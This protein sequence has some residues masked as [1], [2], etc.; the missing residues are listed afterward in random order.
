MYMKKILHR[1]I[2]IENILIGKKADGSDADPG[3]RGILIDLYMAIQWDGDRRNLS[4]EQRLVC[5]FPRSQYP[6]A[7]LAFLD[8]A[9][10]SLSSALDVL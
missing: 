2:T 7:D 6:D 3:Y 8:L 9:S 4:A 1:N 10:M 5:T